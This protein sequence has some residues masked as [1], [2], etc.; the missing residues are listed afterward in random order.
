MISH[1]KHVWSHAGSVC[2]KREGGGGREREGRREREGGGGKRGYKESMCVC[3]LS[4]VCLYAVYVD[5]LSCDW[6]FPKRHSFSYIYHCGG[7]GIP[8]VSMSCD[9]QVM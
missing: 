6:R 8:Q 9:C 1:D 3:L 7:W 4:S 5:E 2:P